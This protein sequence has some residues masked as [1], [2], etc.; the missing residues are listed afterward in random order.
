MAGRAQLVIY[1]PEGKA[2]REHL[3]HNLNIDFEIWNLQY[4]LSKLELPS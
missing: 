1:L 3:T 2:D 4:I